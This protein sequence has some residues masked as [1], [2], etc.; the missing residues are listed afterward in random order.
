MLECLR[1]IIYLK[2]WYMR[3]VRRSVSRAGWQPCHYSPTAVWEPAEGPPP[4][5]SSHLGSPSA[6]PADV[7]I[8]LEPSYSF[9]I[10]TTPLY[11]LIFFTM[12]YTTTEIK[13]TKFD[14]IYLDFKH[15]FHKV[16]HE[17]LSEIKHV[18]LTYVFG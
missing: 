1:E 18:V 2:A 3:E 12:I 8:Y 10:S 7:V 9:K 11:T 15:A 16:P 5:P 4:P 14:I 6:P 13:G 17:R